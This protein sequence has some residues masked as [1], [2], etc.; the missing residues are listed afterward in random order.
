MA[1]LVGTKVFV[2]ELVA[3]SKLG[4]TTRFRDEIIANGTF[5]LYRNGTYALPNDIVRIWNVR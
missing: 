4:K 1:K 2:N 3:F 5:D